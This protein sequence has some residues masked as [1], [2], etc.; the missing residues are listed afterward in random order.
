M[1]P[2]SRLFPEE[3]LDRGSFDRSSVIAVAENGAHSKT[4]ERRFDERN[5]ANASPLLNFAARAVSNHGEKK[6]KPRRACTTLRG[7]EQFELHYTCAYGK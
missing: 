3:S 4:Y 1:F 5:T 6:E 7:T 2:S